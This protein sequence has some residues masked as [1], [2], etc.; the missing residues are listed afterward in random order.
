MRGAS[1]RRRRDAFIACRLQ[2]FRHAQQASHKGA[3]AQSRSWRVTPEL[4]SK[5]GASPPATRRLSRSTACTASASA[6]TI[7]RS[8]PGETGLPLTSCRLRFR[9]LCSARSKPARAWQVIKRA[10]IAAR[11]G[12]CALALAVALGSYWLAGW[13]AVKHGPERAPIRT[14]TSRRMPRPPR[15]RTAIV[16]GA[17]GQDGYF[18]VHRLL[19]DGWHVWAPV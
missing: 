9:G 2:V 12:E 11:G 8:H 6:L 7:A 17:T 5:N 4:L 18:L 19:H 3:R 14:Y 13:R 15:A 16:T 1:T 10:V